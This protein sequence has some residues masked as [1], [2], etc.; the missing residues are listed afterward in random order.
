MNT[1]S[2]SDCFLILTL[3]SIAGFA[4]VILSGFWH[5]LALLGLLAALAWFW[6]S[7]SPGKK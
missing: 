2:W 4:L 3:L 7:A 5:V 6:L 1:P